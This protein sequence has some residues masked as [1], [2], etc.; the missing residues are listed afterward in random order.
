MGWRRFLKWMSDSSGPRASAGRWSCAAVFEPLEPRL[1]LAGDLPSITLIEADNRGLI[2]LTASA[3]LNAST[4]N[5]ASVEVSTAGADQIF[6]TSDDALVSRS[7][8]YNASTRQVRISANVAADARYRVRL[9]S[10]IITGADGRQLDGEFTGASTISGDGVQGGDLVFFSKRPTEF[11]A[12]FTSIS[13]I[14]DVTL[15][16]DRTPLTVQNFLTYANR[17]VWDLTFIHR[18]VSGFV[19]QGG[20]FS[21]QGTNNYPRITQD[22]PVL[23]EPGIS[24]LRGTIAMAKLGGDPNSATN[25]WFFSLGNNASNLDNQNGGFTVFGEVRASAGLSVMDALAAFQVVNAQSVNGAFNEIPV[26]DRNVVISRPGSLTLLTTDLVRFTRIALLVDVSGEAS[27]QL[28]EN[29][30]VTI[31]GSASDNAPRVQVFD[32]DQSGLGDLSDVIQVRFGRNGSITGITIRDGLPSARIGIAITNAASVGSITDARR[33]TSGNIAFIISSAPVGSI[34]I[35]AALTGFDLNGFVVPGLALGDDI[36]GDGDFTDPVAIFVQSGFLSTLRFDDGVTGDVVLPGGMGQVTVRGTARNADFSSEATS[37]TRVPSFTFDSVIDSEVRLN[38]P[39]SSIRAD[40]WRDTGGREERIAA[41]SLDSLRI[42]GDFDAGLNL[43]RNLG[44]RDTLGN[45]R[46]GGSVYR[47]AWVIMGQ[48]GSLTVGGEG[49]SWTLINATNAGTISLGR[50]VNSSFAFSGRVARVTAVDWQ[51]GSFVAALIPNMTIKGDARNGVAGDFIG[52]IAANAG[53]TNTSLGT[54]TING[55][56]RDGRITVTGNAAKATI[57]GGVVNSTFQVNAGDLRTLDSGP[58]TNSTINV[59]RQLVTLNAANFENA[60][61]QG[62][63]YVTINSK[64][65]ARTGAPGD[66]SGEIRLASFRTMSV[67]GNFSGQMNVRNVSAI[68]IGG[69]VNSSLLNFS[70]AATSPSRS[71]ETL[72]IGGMMMA[73]EVRAAGRAG[74]I[75]ADAMMDSGVY[76]GAPAGTVGMVTSGN[77]FINGSSLQ[78]LTLRGMPNGAVAYHNS[79]V[80]ALDVNTVRVKTAAPDN[81]GRI[82][83]MSI[84]TINLVE[85]RVGGTNVRLTGASTT[86]A[87]IG[88]FN[89]FIGF[90]PPPGITI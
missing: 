53:G 89:V 48:I 50:M 40:E 52:T 44:Q 63:A 75:F 21:A 14:I 71:F 34:R 78:E 13:G 9:N 49:S 19:I 69:D 77:G 17:G 56:L 3:S 18:S 37:T 88:D 20:G 46:I 51:G 61:L 85:A 82:Y 79:Y 43:S 87:P 65:D 72:S 5:S 8:E 2:V 45:A 25:E 12:R 84:G 80:V 86:P 68:S 36:D 33:T 1:L 62:G 70:L 60:S 4:V 6:G 38:V 35:G 42:D 10:S 23:N 41:P 26:V 81:F 67:K 27:Q 54:L 15:F 73:S 59:Q 57:K 7:V 74:R 31:S 32:L 39:I 55:A 76:V 83:G 64:G 16:R 90:T 22:A 47:S 24:N 28:N 58:I 66:F 30:S 11:V 29:G